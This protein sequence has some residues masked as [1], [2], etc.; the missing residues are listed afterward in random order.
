MNFSVPSHSYEAWEQVT[1]LAP[2]LLGAS[3]A[4]AI[5]ERRL[6]KRIHIWSRREVS[7]A[8]LSDK[9]WCDAVFDT[10]G[11]ACKDSQ[12]ILLGPPVDWIAPLFREILPNLAPGTL[13]TDV[14]STKSRI[15]RDCQSICPDHIHFV[16]AHP[17]AGSEKT[18]MD[19]ARADLFEQRPCIITP[20]PETDSKAAVRV[21]TFWQSLGS[22]C[23][24]SSPEEHDEIVAH[25]SHLPHLIASCLCDFLGSKD[26]VWHNLA[27]TGFKDTT[28]IASGDPTLWKAIVEENREEILRSLDAFQDRLQLLRSALA[29]QN[30]IEVVA[31]L[32]K[33]K[34][35]RD[36]LSAAP[37]TEM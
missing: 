17:M 37:S 11:A 33:G 23:T 1:I 28:R 4:M 15:C 19:H 34:E 26:P 20:L 8:K 13:V 2:G 14:G 32:Q 16:G 30:M 3:V 29:N 18:G 10:P 27:G 31:L 6:A 12:L 7:R 9:A 35:L 25:I 24:Q 21:S 36:R 5:R 22:I